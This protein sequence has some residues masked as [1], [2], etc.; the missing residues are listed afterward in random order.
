MFVIFVALRSVAHPCIQRSLLDQAKITAQA[1]A[2]AVA[3]GAKLAKELAT[4]TYEAGKELVF[5]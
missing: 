5:S 1:T 2:E 3:E 4:S